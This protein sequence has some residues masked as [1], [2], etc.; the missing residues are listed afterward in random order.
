M[1]VSGL[2][3]LPFLQLWNSLQDKAVDGGRAVNTNAVVEALRMRF[4]AFASEA[5]ALLTNVR[6]DIRTSLQECAYHVSRLV[7]LAYP[8]LP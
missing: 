1:L 2:R 3:T 4:G 7:N 8:G 5:Q 6:R